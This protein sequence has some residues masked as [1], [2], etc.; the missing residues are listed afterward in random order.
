[1]EQ[2]VDGQRMSE[3]LA[4]GGAADGGAE[5]AGAADGG[6]ASGGVESAGVA[7]IGAASGGV[8]SAGEVED[9]ACSYCLSRDSHIEQHL[10][11][12]FDRVA[13]IGK[14]GNW[15]AHHASSIL[16]IMESWL[17]FWMGQK[18][19]CITMCINRMRPHHHFT[20]YCKAD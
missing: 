16:A 2:W 1:M 9:G 10:N 14:G 6:A 11:T 12:S 18:L 20:N 4:G 17:M 13:Y 19:T 3:H 7:D 8:E 5:S 15:P